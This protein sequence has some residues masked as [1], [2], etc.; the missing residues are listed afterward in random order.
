MAAG[1][2]VSG[3]LG[4][5]QVVSGMKAQS[6]QKRAQQQAIAAQGQ[7]AVDE[8]KLRQIDIQNAKMYSQYQAQMGQLSRLQAFQQQSSGLLAQAQMEQ[9]Q[10]AAS[11][12]ENEQA[13]MQAL[14]SA[15]QQKQQANQQRL[16]ATLNESEAKQQAAQQAGGVFDQLTQSEQQTG[17]MLN[18]GQARR[19]TM[20]AMFAASGLAPESLT[21][22]ALQSSDM[23]NDLAVQ[24]EQQLK[25]SNL[26][27]QAAFDMLSQGRIAELVK[28]LGFEDAQRMDDEAGRASQYANTVADATNQN[29]NATLGQNAAARNA[30]MQQFKG[31]MALDEQ[32]DKANQLFA[33][34]GFNAQT[35]ATQASLDSTMKG[36]AASSSA[37]PSGGGFLGLL[38][39][40]LSVYNNVSSQMDNSYKRD[41]ELR[42]GLLNGIQP[43]TSS[44][45]TLLGSLRNYRDTK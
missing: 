39:G 4:A 19:A 31:S 2:A 22:N 40:G 5:A 38:S 7:A 27:E 15:E 3:V 28:A 1:A 10:A 37:I 18:E 30:A 33:N 24:V 45:N 43:N 11:Q 9:M 34:S 32:T 23:M 21:S 42:A 13:R 35:N 36:L 6:S 14:T 44:R 17:Q 25:A 16:G 29:I 41:M 12:F 20:E 8:A 26:S